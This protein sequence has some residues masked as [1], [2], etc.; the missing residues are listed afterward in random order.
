LG[1][2]LAVSLTDIWFIGQFAL[3]VPYWDDWNFIPYAAGHMPITWEWLWAFQGDHRIALPKL[4]FTALY[5]LGHGD[6]RV[7]MYANLAILSLVGLLGIVVVRRRRRSTSLADA[8]IPLALAGIANYVNLISANQVQYISSI[9]LFCLAVCLILWQPDWF[10]L[11]TLVLLVVCVVCLPLTG[12]TGVALDLPLVVLLAIGAF[13]HR[14]SERSDVKRACW[15]AVTAIITAV[16]VLAAYGSWTDRPASPV[17][18]AASNLRQFVQGTLQLAAVGFMAPPLTQ[19]RVGADW[20]QRFWVF[21]SAIVVVAGASA[22]LGLIREVSLRR[23]GLLSVLGPLACMASVACLA[24]V[25][26]L[27]RGSALDQRYV[28]LG[29]TLL[30]TI[31]MCL[32]L[33]RHRLATLAGWGLALTALILVPLNA[34][35]AISFGEARQEFQGDLVR[36]IQ[37]GMPVDLLATRYYEDI[38]GDPVLA[39]SAISEMRDD[40]IGPFADRSLRLND[41]NPVVYG[42][43]TV[44]AAPVAVHNMTRVGDYWQ[45]SG[46]DSFLLYSI[47]QRN[48]AG[49]RLTYSLTNATERPAFL[50]LAWSNSPTGDFD[51]RGNRFVVYGAPATNQR[52]QVIAWIGD[53]VD[54]L[55]VTPDTQ[56]SSFKVD[57]IEL[58]LSK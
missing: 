57:S 50:Q 44:S 34:Y 5:R 38:W 49:V 31:Y 12:S 16:A 9:V 58:L 20:P 37:A 24:V 25:I 45:G 7:V 8:F 47:Q 46:G 39:A 10:R 29:A 28:I 22:V 17:V 2:L 21:G 43:Q 36:D 3:N 30:F 41:A 4:L 32:S 26:G 51:A 40:R 13:A 54:M 48:L 52:Q 11:S 6:V 23:T 15:I 55:K 35:Y 42:E 27:E 14:N 18:L 1:F 56:P 19:L 53:S 33:V